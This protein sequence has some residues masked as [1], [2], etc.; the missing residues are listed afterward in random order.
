M[1]TVFCF[2]YLSKNSKGSIYTEEYVKLKLATQSDSLSIQ[3]MLDMNKKIDSTRVIE[4]LKAKTE[5]MNVVYHR[6]K[7][8]KLNKEVMQKQSIIDSLT[9]INA[10]CEEQLIEYKSQNY[11]LKLQV[12]E[13]DSAYLALDIEAESYSRDSYLCNVQRSNDSILIASLNKSNK[14]L[15]L[16]ISKVECTADWSEKHKFLSWLFGIK[17]KN[18]Q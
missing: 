4:Q 18:I 10:P 2:M 11:K 14:S 1:L 5:H 3:H 16:Y 7:A 6:N 15:K 17:C 12:I 13:L 8:D 9:N